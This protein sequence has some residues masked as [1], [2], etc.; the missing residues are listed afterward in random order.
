M[1]NTDLYNY[2]C[3]YVYTFL[4]KFYLFHIVY[5]SIYCVPGKGTP[6]GEQKQTWSLFLWSLTAYC[7]KETLIKESYN[8]TN[9]AIAIKDRYIL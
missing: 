6:W 2:I 5:G 9:V 8:I 1:I 7:R 3:K 4:I